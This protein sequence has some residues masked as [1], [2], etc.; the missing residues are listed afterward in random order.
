MSSTNFT[1]ALKDYTEIMHS[2]W[3]KEVHVTISN[4]SGHPTVSFAVLTLGILLCLLDPPYYLRFI[5]NLGSKS[6]VR[7][8]YIYY[9]WRRNLSNV[10][11]S[12]FSIS[13]IQFF[14]ASFNYFSSSSPAPYK[15]SPFSKRPLFRLFSDFFKQTI[16]TNFTTN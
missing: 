13:E 4:Q 8:R 9:S 2:D 1:I 5:V 14:E 12:F 11:K 6:F 3:L 15:S 7:R 10:Y 16:R